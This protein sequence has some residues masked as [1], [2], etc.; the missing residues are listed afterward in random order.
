MFVFVST[1]FNLK[2][3]NYDARYPYIILSGM[4]V[5]GA[6]CGLFLPETLHQRL[7]DNI[8]EASVFGANQ[9]FTSSLLYTIYFNYIFWII[10]EI[11]VIA[12]GTTTG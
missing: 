3:T 9:V 12:E 8:E 5:F 1:K 2:G 7:P 10:A 6:F 4:F 11:L